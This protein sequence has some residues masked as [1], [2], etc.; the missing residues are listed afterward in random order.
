[1]MEATVIIILLFI[2]FNGHT[3]VQILSDFKCEIKY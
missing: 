1:M 2:C 3:Y